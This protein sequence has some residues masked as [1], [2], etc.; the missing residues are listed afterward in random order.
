MTESCRLAMQGELQRCASES[1]ALVIRTPPHAR[2][3]LRALLRLA[4]GIRGVT[5][6]ADRLAADA[7]TATI[8]GLFVDG[9]KADRCQA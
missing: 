4:C 5:W 6:A 2:T 8:Q 1:G 7:P 3:T 9:A